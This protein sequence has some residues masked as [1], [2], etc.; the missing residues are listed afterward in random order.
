M[1]PHT[2]SSASAP[3]P[4]SGVQI[5]NQATLVNP[6]VSQRAD[7]SVYRH[8]D[9][10]YYLTDSVPAYDLIELRRARTL[11]GLSSATPVVVHRVAGSG[12]PKRVDMGT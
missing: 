11:Q 7:P 9:G 6:V 10:Y 2:L 8:T 1:S 3:Q 12:A 5:P 4:S